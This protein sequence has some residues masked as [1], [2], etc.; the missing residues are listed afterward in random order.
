MESDFYGDEYLNTTKMH[1]VKLRRWMS[2]VYFPI[3]MCA[4]KMLNK[5]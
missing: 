5:I 3:K 4:S 2:E 1:N